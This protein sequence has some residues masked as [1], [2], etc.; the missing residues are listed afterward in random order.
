MQCPNCSIC[1]KKEATRV[2]SLERYVEFLC[3]V[4]VAEGDSAGA[5]AFHSSI[6]RPLIDVELDL[7]WLDRL[8]TMMELLNTVTV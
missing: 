5:L 1:W 4:G 2:G 7:V 8:A 3:V 6:E